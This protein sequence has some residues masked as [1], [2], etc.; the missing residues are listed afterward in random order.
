MLEHFYFLRQGGMETSSLVNDLEKVTGPLEGIA[1]CRG[2]LLG[3]ISPYQTVGIF[4]IKLFYRALLT[5]YTA[6]KSIWKSIK[7]CKSYSQN[8]LA[9]SPHAN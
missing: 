5:L 2:F 3:T 4:G 6:Q 9:Q 7:H 1:G 8:H